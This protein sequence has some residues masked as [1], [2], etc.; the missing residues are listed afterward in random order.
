M[1]FSVIGVHF[2]VIG[3]YFLAKQVVSQPGVQ[4]PEKQIKKGFNG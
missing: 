3:I 2:L 1:Y 4:V